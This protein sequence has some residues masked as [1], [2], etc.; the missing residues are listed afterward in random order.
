MSTAPFSAKATLI[1]GAAW[2]VAT[3]WSIKA[4]GFVNTMVMARLLMPSEYGVVAMAMLVVGLIQAFLDLGATTAL[5]RKDEVTRDEIDSVWTL[6]LL[7]SVVIGLVLVAVSPLAARYFSDERVLHVLWVF[8]ACTTLA[9]AGNIGVTLAHKAF[10]FFLEFRIQVLGKL[11]G[12]VVTIVSGYLLRDYRALVL[13]VASGYMSGLVFSFAMHPYRPRWNTS[14]I[15]EIWAL[16]KWLMASGVGGFILRKGDELIAGRVGTSAQFGVYNVGSD[17][18]QMPAGEVGPAIL[19]AFLPILSALQGTA[20][21]IN[22]AVIK[23]VSAVNTLTLAIG[24][25]FAA[26]ATPATLVVLGSGWVDAVPYVAAFAVISA[27]QVMLNPLSTLL[28]LRGHTKVQSHIVWLEFAGFVLAAALLVP[29]MSLMGLVWA[30]GVGLLVGG[31]ACMFF[32]RRYCGLRIWPTLA[33]IARPLLGALLMFWIVQLC[34]GT[35]AAPWA[36]L[37]VGICSGAV[38]Y[39]AWC[40]SSWWLVGRPEG[41][42]STVWDAVGARYRAWRLSR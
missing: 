17:L 23:T 39:T 26:I 20:E 5:L 32:T 16:T 27:I 31:T 14:K 13:G 8:A 30:R 1:R 25:G 37:A 28:V 11:V 24:L 21:Q 4:L 12:I 19:K 18:G 29:S 2:T 38:F 34:I 42:E 41:L 35:V 15:A 10:D 40:V 3:R 36:K 33:A 7:Q 9:G 6:R 22:A